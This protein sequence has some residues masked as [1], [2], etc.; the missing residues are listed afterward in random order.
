VQIGSPCLT[1]SPTA[2]PSECPTR[3]A[4]V[5]CSNDTDDGEALLT[6]SISALDANTSVVPNTTLTSSSTA[7]LSTEPL[8]NAQITPN[9]DRKDGE[10]TLSADLKFAG[11]QQHIV[12][13]N[14]TYSEA[15]YSDL[16]VF[17]SIM[18]LLLVLCLAQNMDDLEELVQVILPSCD[19]TNAPNISKTALNFQQLSAT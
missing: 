12:L 14:P 8:L 16:P 4:Q 10:K 18:Q 7:V 5:A 3:H 6:I 1:S 11:D 19:R 2:F 17:I 9:D 15:D 13:R